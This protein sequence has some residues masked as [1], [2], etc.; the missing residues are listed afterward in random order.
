MNEINKLAI[1]IITED[2]NIITSDIK[3]VDRAEDPD[4][5]IV[6]TD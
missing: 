4:I 3:E 5:S 2:S 6:N 1:D